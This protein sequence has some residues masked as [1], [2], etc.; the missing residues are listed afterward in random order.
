MLATM[1]YISMGGPNIGQI[2][3][4]IFIVMLCSL[5]IA[6]VGGGATAAGLMVFGT[7]GWPQY[8]PIV[9]ILFSVEALI[10]MGRTTLN[11]SGGFVAGVVAGRFSG[12][13]NLKGGDH[14][15]HGG[16]KEEAPAEAGATA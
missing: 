6:G 5:G 12:A 1:V 4:L 10:D 16:E 13:L 3:I 2:I 11:V 15:L 9:G 14:H 8:I 7:L